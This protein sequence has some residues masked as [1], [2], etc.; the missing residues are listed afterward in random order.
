MISKNPNHSRPFIDPS[1]VLSMY[2]FS[3]FFSRRGMVLIIT[4]FAHKELKL[5][6]EKNYVFFDFSTFVRLF[7][8]V[9][10]G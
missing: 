8:R 5:R 7:E 3:F 4:G 2:T 1:I 6:Y 9:F 10:D